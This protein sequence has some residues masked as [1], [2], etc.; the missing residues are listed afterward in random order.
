MSTVARHK[1]T[2]KCMTN[3]SKALSEAGKA[4]TPAN[5]LP[6]DFFACPAE[7]VAR[8]LIGKALVRDIDGYRIVLRITETEA[9]LGPHD[10]AC[11][12]SKG[13]TKRTE[14]LYG[15]PGALY[16]YLIYGMYWMLNVVVEREGYPAG[17]LLRGLEGLSGPGRLT[18]ALALDGKLNGLEATPQAGLWFADVGYAPKRG[19]ISRTPRIGIAYA[20]AVWSAKKLRFVERDGR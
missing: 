14:T 8:E 17:V 10:L 1:M 18:R 15:P 16:L 5:H 2:S 7:R 12:A 9:Y 3:A 6:R 20:G 19:A 4:S 11:H 13:R